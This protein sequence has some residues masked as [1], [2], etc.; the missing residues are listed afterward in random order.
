[1]PLFQQFVLFHA[2]MGEY[3]LLQTLVLVLLVGLVRL[4]VVQ[5]VNPSF[6]FFFMPHFILFP[7]PLFCVKSHLFQ[8]FALFFAKME[9]HALPQ[10]LVLV[11]LVGLEQPLGVQHVNT[12]LLVICFIL[13]LL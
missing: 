5:H 11:L 8:Q 10:T 12:P 1:L 9:E 6:V 4:L 13:T 2:K 3:A 7:S